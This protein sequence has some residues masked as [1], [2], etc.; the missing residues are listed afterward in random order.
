MLLRTTDELAEKVDGHLSVNCEGM[1]NVNLTCVEE[2]MSSIE[3]QVSVNRTQQ[4]E[5]TAVLNAKIDEVKSLHIDMKDSFT[6]KIKDV[7]KTS[8]IRLTCE[9]LVCEKLSFCYVN[10]LCICINIK[11]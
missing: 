9:C 8:M 5:D 4:I 7:D 2:K 1:K 10:A 6:K 3:S 11:Y